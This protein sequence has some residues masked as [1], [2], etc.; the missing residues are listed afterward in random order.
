MPGTDACSA[1]VAHAPAQEGMEPPT[2][3]SHTLAQRLSP[4]HRRDVQMTQAL[5]MRLVHAVPAHV[6]V[7]C[8]QGALRGQ[9]EGGVGEG[10]ADHPR[11]A[12]DRCAHASM[13]PTPTVRASAHA[14]QIPSPPR[15][16]DAA[17]DQVIR[18]SHEREPAVVARGRDWSSR[19]PLEG[20]VAT[21]CTLHT[22]QQ[23]SAPVPAPHAKSIAH[24]RGGPHPFS[25]FPLPSPS[26]FPYHPPFLPP[27]LP[28]PPPSPRSDRRTRAC[29]WFLGPDARPGQTPCTRQAC[30]MTHPA[31]AWVRGWWRRVD[32][33]P[34]WGDGVMGTGMR[35][36]TGTDQEP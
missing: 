34:G 32:Q 29:D 35:A 5:H 23:P 1:K 3:R 25:P 22:P 2:P 36:G 12:P 13:P 4:S 20:C 8:H 28:P 6:L 9:E 10:H 14:P 16:V 31:C 15:T 30:R 18:E 21:C 11:R 19:A 24:R 7:H 26:P 33:D 27:L 17:V